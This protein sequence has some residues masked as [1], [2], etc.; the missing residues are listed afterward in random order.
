MPLGLTIARNGNGV[1][2]LTQHNPPH[3][4]LDCKDWGAV[5]LRSVKPNRTHD[6]HRRLHQ[7]YCRNSL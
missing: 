4:N 6:K 2:Q 5:Y 3:T 1:N 7:K